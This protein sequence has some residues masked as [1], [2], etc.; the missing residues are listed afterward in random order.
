MIRS[1]Q[2]LSRAKLEQM[3]TPLVDRSMEPV[4]KALIELIAENQAE[5]GDYT[6]VSGADGAA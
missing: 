4:K 6:A 5:G 3:I 1:E 2:P